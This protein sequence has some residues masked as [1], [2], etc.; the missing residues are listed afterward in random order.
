MK[1]HR[2]DVV[3]F[4]FG[5]VFLALSVWWLL[6]RILGLTLPPVGWFLAG[7]LILIGLL[8]LLGAL[9]SGRHTDGQPA[10]PEATVEAPHVDG[11]PAT[12]V[13]AT[14]AD[15]WPAEAVTEVPAE[16]RQDRPADREPLWSPAPAHPGGGTEPV[17]RELPTFDD[18]DRPGDPAAGPDT[19]GDGPAGT[20]RPP[21]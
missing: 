3:S 17:T 14:G 20:A 2:T 12:A 21:G 6:G 7:A 19:G 18:P 11:A 8:G 16:A 9:R 15:E 4:A 10:H 5:L 1:A 13:P